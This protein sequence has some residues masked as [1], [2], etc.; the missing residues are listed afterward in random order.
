MFGLGPWELLLVFLAVLLLF[1]AKRIPE[2]MRGFGQGLR[3]T[4]SKVQSTRARSRRT[5]LQHRRN[6][7]TTN[8]ETRVELWAPRALRKTSSG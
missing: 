6:R 7:K 4:R 1:G 5:L 2:I 3:E 8:N